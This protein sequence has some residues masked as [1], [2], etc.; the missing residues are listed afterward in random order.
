V[1]S[2]D[3]AEIVVHPSGRFLY[4]SNRGRD[5]IAIFG[6][7]SSKGTLTYLADVPTQ[8]RTPRN[9]GIDPTGN[10]LLTANQDGNNLVLFRIDPRTGG[11]T[12]TGDKIEAGAPVCVE[13]LPIG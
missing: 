11:L 1:C 4:G 2:S 10:F 9:F 7:H 6:I 12:P 5:S 8:G 3:L 13:F